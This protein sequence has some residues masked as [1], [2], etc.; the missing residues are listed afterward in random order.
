MDFILVTVQGH[1]HSRFPPVTPVPLALGSLQQGHSMNRFS[2]LTTGQAI[3]R[4]LPEAFRVLTDPAETGAVTISL[5]EDVQAE[6]HDW[7][8]EFFEKRVWHVRRPV[9]EPE[10]VREAVKLLKAAK[11]PVIISGGGTIY[12][13]STG[14]VVWGTR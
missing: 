9:P 2:R 6:A 10:L 7:P 1:T 12:T 14:F 3:V 4:F 5:P 13:W 8:I 11:R